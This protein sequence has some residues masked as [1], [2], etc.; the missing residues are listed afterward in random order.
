LL[1]AEAHFQLGRDLKDPKLAREHEDAAIEILKKL[2]EDYPKSDAAISSYLVEADYYA[3]RNKIDEARKSLKKLADDFPQSAY[4]PHALYQ[5][6]LL[7]ERLGQTSGYEEANRLL[8]DLVTK[9]PQ[10]DLVFYAQLREGGLLQK[11]NQLPSAQLVFMELLN[12]FSQHGD[13]TLAQLA[14]AECINAQSSG[15]PAFLDIAK[16][17]FEELRDR[18]D[19]PIDVRVEAGYNLGEV[20]VRRNQETAA[21]GVWWNLVVV[22]FLEDDTRAV[23]LG[24]TG[25]YWMARTLIRTGEIY[26]K[27]EKLEEAKKAWTY[28]LQKRLPFE[29]L[30]KSNLREVGVLDP[31]P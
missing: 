26:Q 5:A 6:A 27:Q 1:K 4:A 8:V 3:N 22:P 9:Y 29:S 15:N 21:I 30:A 11:L 18:V 16:T 2:R 14:L 24:T 20:L 25:R 17:K 7:A 28:I 13:V 12:K 10:S 31:K 19:A 23:T